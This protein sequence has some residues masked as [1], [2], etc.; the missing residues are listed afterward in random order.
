MAKRKET[1]PMKLTRYEQETI[2]NFNEEEP[3]ATVYT[4]NKKLIAKLN[5]FASTRPEE[6]E[7]IKEEYGSYTFTVPKSWV[8]VAPPRKLSKQT[9]EKLAECCARMRNAKAN[10]NQF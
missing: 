4:Y 10:R 7:F 6:C 8:K 9:K 2:L 3:L 1:K 5:E